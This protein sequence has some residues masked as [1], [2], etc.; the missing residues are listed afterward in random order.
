MIRNFFQTL[1][2]RRR[3]WRYAPLSEV[4]ELYASR[5]LRTAALYMISTFVS[6]YLYQI[7][8][9]VALIALYWAAFYAFKVA[10]T[11]PIARCVAWIGPKRAIFISN[12]LYIPAMV[13]YALL[14]DY[15]I[16]LLLIAPVFQG[17]SASMYSIAYNI[18][19]SKVKNFQHAG[20][21]IAYMNIFE[22]ITI[23]LSPLIGGLVAAIWGPQTVIVISAALFAVAAVPLF[24]TGERVRVNQKLVFR[25]F[26]WRLFFSHAVAQTSLGFDMFTSG[27]V[28][29][30][31]I[32]IIVLGVTS[33]SNDVYAIT[34][35]LLSV[36]FLV[37]IVASY[38]YGRLIDRRKGGDLM[39]V[40]T[41]A[42]AI[43]HFLR[44]FAV[45]PVM[46]L[47]LNAANE[48]ATTA[49][50]LP[51]TRALFDNAD[52]SGTRVTY[53]GLVDILS[54]VGATIAA[55]VLAGGA[56]IFGDTVALH[57][58]FFVAGAV[59]LLL[60]TARF[61]LYKK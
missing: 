7:G 39:R 14:P 19:F 15:G 55:L 50:S 10:M 60:L 17:I 34:G 53:L 3:F 45:S 22:K 20:K 47:G 24:K 32:A 29:S 46:V 43:T 21:Q 26:P 28:W 35:L 8:G 33:S 18:D 41:I 57:G 42:N 11:L 5:V 40:G 37:A 36:V 4:A 61:P 31:Y 56:L 30:L 16:W 9:S 49:Y 25:G 58:F 51:Y 54:N 44:P 2:T 6:I 12:I 38:T 1:L 27:T 13:A 23:G 48:M 52:L 59:M